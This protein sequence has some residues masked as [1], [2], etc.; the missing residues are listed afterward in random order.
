MCNE[1][2]DTFSLVPMYRPQRRAMR[3]TTRVPDP[4]VAP[5]TIGGVGIDSSAKLPNW[6]IPTVKRLRVVQ[7]VWASANPGRGQS[8]AA[9][10][11]APES[12]M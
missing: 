9:S 11:P 1:S 5:I 4:P 12:V 6:V 10:F 7:A 2:F 3:A 8:T